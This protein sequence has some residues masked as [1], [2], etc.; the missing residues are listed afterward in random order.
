M[1]KF[2]LSNNSLKVIT[3]LNDKGGSR[4]TMEIVFSL[5]RHASNYYTLH[6]SDIA[7]RAAPLDPRL[8]ELNDLR[9]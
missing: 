1:I 8:N 9:P 3:S 6:R 4:H 5:K 7:A 2:E